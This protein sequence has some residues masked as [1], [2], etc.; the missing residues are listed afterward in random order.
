LGE[1]E[2]LLAIAHEPIDE[3]RDRCLETSKEILEIVNAN[4]R[5]RLDRR[6]DLR[7]FV[8]TAWA[9]AST[10]T[11][12]RRRPTAV[13]APGS[14]AARR[15]RGL[16]RLAAARVGA[17]ALGAGASRRFG[18]PEPLTRGTRWLLGL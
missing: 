2:R 6:Y 8:S 12:E 3:V 16:L 18:D 9:T 4:Q 13:S 11:G 10:L 1:I 14:A 15:P 7:L 5:T 17:G